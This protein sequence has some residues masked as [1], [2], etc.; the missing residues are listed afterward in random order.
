[1]EFFTTAIE[2][3]TTQLL[4]RIATDYNLPCE[5]LI[6]KYLNKTVKP[7]VVKPKVLKVPMEERMICPG[8]TGKKKTPCK[9]K[10]KAGTNA[11][12][13]HNKEPIVCLPCVPSVPAPAPALVAPSPPS[14]PE[15]APEPVQVPV[16]VPVKVAKKT[17]AKAAPEPAPEPVIA[18]VAKPKSKKKVASPSPAP[19]PE[20]EPTVAKPKSKKK[21]P[22]PVVAPAPVIAPI[23][24]PVS[25]TEP[26]QMSLD[27]RLRMILANGGNYDDDEEAEE[28]I[29]DRDEPLSPGA[30]RH[31]MI[32]E[33]QGKSWA[34]YQYDDDEE[35]EDYNEEAILEEELIN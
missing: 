18:A 16:P 27:D 28:E 24:K 8:L 20:P 23:V 34:D 29:E 1:M 22:T 26:S 2:K 4:T 9:N 35:E 10:C 15:P 7:K 32:V 25:E 5:D 31:K 6:A 21:A 30:L 13:I 33:S 14:S 17:K 3:A 11:C 19:V 12:H